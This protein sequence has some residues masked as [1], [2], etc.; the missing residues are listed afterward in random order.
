MLSRAGFFLFVVF[1]PHAEIRTGERFRYM[2][3]D[4]TLQ[5]L[6]TVTISRVD[7]AYFTVYPAVDIL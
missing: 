6:S 5:H 4:P 3:T 7:N 1:P 2:P